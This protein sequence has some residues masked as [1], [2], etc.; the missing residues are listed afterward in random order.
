[1]L[2][3]ILVGFI[4]HEWY[5]FPEKLA[6]GVSEEVKK[7]FDNEFIE[8]NTGIV[9][10]II[11]YVTGDYAKKLGILIVEEDPTFANDIDDIIKLVAS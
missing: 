7:E 6:K 4:I 9:E 3:P 8:T 10:E 1:M 11:K 2:I 5:S